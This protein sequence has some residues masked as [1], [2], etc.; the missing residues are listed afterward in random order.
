MPHSFPYIDMIR[1]GKNITRLRKNNNLK[2][3]DI[4]KIF[5]FETPQAIYKWQ[6]GD[7][8]PSIDNLVMLAKIFNTT[9]DK[10]IIIS[11]NW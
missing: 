10:I 4:Q 5:G 9:I 3:Q 11:E 7:S 2:V 6:R 8:L 1:T